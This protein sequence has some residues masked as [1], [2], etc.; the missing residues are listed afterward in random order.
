M[1][2]MIVAVAAS[3]CSLAV[4]ISSAQTR[5]KGAA[6]PSP[7]PQRPTPSPTAT[8]MADSPKM[9]LTAPSVAKPRPEYQFPVGQ[10][11]VYGGE[12]RIFNAGVATLRLEQAGREDHVIGTATATGTVA[13]LFHVLDRYESFFDPANFCSRNTSRHIEEGLRRVD[14]NITF[15][16]QHSKVIFDQK[17]IRKK[18][19]KHE[20]HEISNCVTDMLSAIYY[21]AS[22]PLMPGGVYN[23]PL[24]D[25]G[26]TITVTVHV[27]AREKIKT[28][29][30]TFDAIRVQPESAKGL[31]K[32]KGR[33]WIW[34]SDD[35]A[36]VP[37]QARTRMSWGTLTIML[38]RIDKK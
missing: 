18:E 14:T 9:V 7:S 23:F 33:I 34:Y 21:V 11:F 27:E 37:V 16:Y 30:G 4:A 20:E 31:L 13:L 8:P 3:A 35:A 5:K 17:N 15:D 24:N 25:G 29:A 1:K 38:Q 10:T 19:S 26:E 2:F 6:T 32:N 28:P 12:W 36:R 22:L